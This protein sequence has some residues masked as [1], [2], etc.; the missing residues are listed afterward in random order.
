MKICWDNLENLRL[1]KNGNFRKGTLTYE[2]RMCE[3]CKDD[4]LAIKCRKDRY[5]D[6]SCAN[7]KEHNPLYGKNLSIEHK[8]KIALAVSKALKGKYTGKKHWLYG[9]H[10]SPETIEKMRK[11]RIFSDKHVKKLSES[12]KQ[13]HKNNPGIMRGNQKYGSPK[14]KN[15]NWKGGI[16]NNP[17]CIEW[18]YVRDELKEDD[19]NECQ[20]T[21]CEGVSQRMT[22]HHID[23]DK[24]NCHPSNVIT[25][26][27]SCN[28]KA[29]TQRDW[30][31][32]FYTEIKRRKMCNE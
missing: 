11:S 29:N 30:W 9:K 32:A 10:R 21:L 31:Q 15:P 22:S 12:M 27:Y 7:T 14:E 1:T 20:N 5:C 17:Y 4:F 28:A 25:L 19:N 6:K 16:S 23:Y 3:T 26:C 13:F 24:Q 2:V 18:K 8:Q